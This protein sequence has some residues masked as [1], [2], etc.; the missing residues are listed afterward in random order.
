MFFTLFSREVVRDSKG[1]GR[2]GINEALTAI[3]GACMEVLE[4]F[5]PE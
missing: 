2:T 4:F 3:R 1:P 5:M